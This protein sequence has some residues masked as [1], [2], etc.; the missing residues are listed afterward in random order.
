VKPFGNYFVEPFVVG[1][2]D[3]NPVEVETAAQVVAR[4][5]TPVVEEEDLAVDS[6]AGLAVEAPVSPTVELVVGPAG[7]LVDSQAVEVELELEVEVL[8]LEL[9][10]ELE[11]DEAA[12]AV[13]QLPPVL[14]S[15]VQFQF[16]RRGMN[17][18]VQQARQV[19]R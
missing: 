5:R 4:E 10:L 14:G 13:G 9:E 6:A 1:T 8:G 11:L 2:V 17:A 3:S 16:P 7:E 12:A 18:K 19:P 15:H